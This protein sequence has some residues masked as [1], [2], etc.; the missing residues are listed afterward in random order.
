MLTI[1][2]IAATACILLIAFG[3][4]DRSGRGALMAGLGTSGIL[5]L[6]VI[7]HAARIGAVLL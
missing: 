5:L 7:L 6:I 1:I 2:M 4:E 3:F